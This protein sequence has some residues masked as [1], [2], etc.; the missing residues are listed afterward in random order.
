MRSDLAKPVDLLCGPFLTQALFKAAP[1]RFFWYS[2]YH[3]IVMDGFSFALVA[4]RVAEVY[5][6]LASGQIIDVGSFGSLALLLEE[7]AAYR[8]IQSASS[9]IVNFGWIASGG[10]AGAHQA[11][12]SI[13]SAHRS[14][15]ER[16]SVPISSVVPTFFRSSTIERASSDCG[17]RRREL[18][19][20]RHVR[21]RRFS[22]IA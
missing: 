15:R 5:T 1:D 11:E 6:T 21:P 10:L 8:A 14:D 2:R 12:H 16:G 18:A 17:A 7:E 3:H 20:S 19:A 22:C 13:A 9:R 4:R